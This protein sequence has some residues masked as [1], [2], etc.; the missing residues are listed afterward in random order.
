MEC[1]AGVKAKVARC[2]VTALLGYPFSS[3]SLFR[4]SP[5]D[6]DC[7][8]EVK[9]V[10]RRSLLRRLSQVAGAWCIRGV[11][12]TRSPGSLASPFRFDAPSNPLVLGSSFDVTLVD[13]AAHAGLNAICV[14]GEKDR[15]RWI[16][17]T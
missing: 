3:M 2:W 13:V 8:S 12:G 10:S 11:G 7:E 1:I 17:E 16:I 14:C 6:A 15:K 4:I 5:R 9:L